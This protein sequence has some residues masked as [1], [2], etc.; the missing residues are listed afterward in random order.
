MALGS[1]KDDYKRS[2]EQWGE[3]PSATKLYEK[4]KADTL[5]VDDI[6]EVL[7]K[8]VFGTSKANASGLRKVSKGK[9]TVD[10]EYVAS[11]ST[12]GYYIL[13]HSHQSEC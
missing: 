3:N 5:I 1:D 7:K 6:Q 10:F 9:S 11:F 4:M 8:G 12:D 2:I 13:Y